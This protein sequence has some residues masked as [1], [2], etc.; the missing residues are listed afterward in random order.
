MAVQ[1]RRVS[2]SRKGMR[3]SHDHLEQPNLGVCETC[4]KAK[5]MHRVC[6]AC[7][8]YKGKKVLDI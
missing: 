3:R 2:Q 4:G 5:Q 6:S 1:Q 7:G 8:T